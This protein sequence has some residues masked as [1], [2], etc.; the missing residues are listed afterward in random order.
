MDQGPF[1][2]WDRSNKSAVAMDTPDPVDEF[3]SLLANNGFQADNKPILDG[4]IHRV[5]LVGSEPGSKDGA[6]LGNLDGQPMGWIQ[7][8][9]TG[10]KT[11]WIHTIQTMAPTEV[12]RL[13]AEKEEICLQKA[14]ERL[15]EQENAIQFAQEY[16]KGSIKEHEGLMNNPDYAKDTY[17]SKNNIK[18]PD[19]VYLVPNPYVNKEQLVLVP[20][21]PTL[22]VD[23]PSKV[24][25][26]QQI[27]I[28]GNTN[29]VFNSE[30][31]KGAMFLI[32]SGQ[33]SKSL[34]NKYNDWIKKGQD[35]ETQPHVIVTSDITSVSTL[36]EATGLPV[37]YA[38]APSNLTE[39]SKVV[40]ETYPEAHI[41]VCEPVVNSFKAHV[42]AK[43]VDG[44]SL[45][46]KIP[47]EQ[48][49]T[50]GFNSL[51]I[52]QTQK[53]VNGYIEGNDILK[54]LSKPP[55]LETVIEA[56]KQTE[57]MP[58]KE[59]TTNMMLFR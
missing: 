44:S 25:T 2:I 23:D 42:A 43:A 45:M 11:V 35:P 33:G 9:K 53:L 19:G 49:E 20:G 30:C 36:S 8:Y 22:K 47:G 32:D 12:E 14:Q 5:S 54:Q 10:E 24:Q 39:V 3:Q 27:D 17:F 51:G 34:E 48:N 55:E 16:L 4:K 57:Q 31:M 18:E 1:K 13:R 50:L 46:A 37:V 58:R 29:Y 41:L 40:K 52:E 6:Y 15:I 28:G 26:V 21:Y 38:F 59:E 7:N 56:T